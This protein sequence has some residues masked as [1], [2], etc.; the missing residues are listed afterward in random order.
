MC[1]GCAILLY[2]AATNAAIV[3]AKNTSW[4]LGAHEMLDALAADE[5]LSHSC[6]NVLVWHESWDIQQG[7]QPKSLL[8]LVNIKGP[9]KCINIHKQ[10]RVHNPPMKQKRSD[11]WQ[12]SES[13]VRHSVRSNNPLVYT[14]GTVNPEQDKADLVSITQN[15]LLHN[16][17]ITY[18]MP[19]SQGPNFCWLRCMADHKKYK[20]CCNLNKREALGE[21]RNY[22]SNPKEQDCCVI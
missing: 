19:Q 15:R 6:N 5:A 16:H 22:L 20:G 11:P 14:H 21:V 8:A 4:C 17:T 3:A 9:E 1:K 10:L 12:I 13:D 7:R 18:P 2:C